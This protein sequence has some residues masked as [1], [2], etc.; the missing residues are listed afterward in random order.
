M[1]QQETKSWN[2]WT[3]SV[4]AVLLA[5]VTITSGCRSNPT[6]PQ[7]LTPVRTAAVQPI[8]AGTSNTY[9]ANIQPYQQV[10]LAFK[11][12]GYLVSIRQVKDAT[13][14][15]RNIDQGDWVAK[16]TV[17]ATVDEGDYKEKLQQAKAQLDRAQANYDRAKLSFDRMSVLYQNG[18]ATKP[19]YDNANAQMLDGLASIQSA[20]ASIAEQ[21]IALGYCEL[22]APFDGWLVKRNVDVGQLVGPATNGFTISD[23]R[24]VK[25]VFGVPDTS[26][27]HIRLGSPETITTD[28]LPG[29]FNG[30]VTSIS[31]SADPKSRVY[32]VEVTIPNGDNR[33]KAGMIASIS[34]GGG[35]ANTRVDVVPLTAVVRSPGNPNG[36]AVFV[37]EGAG[38]TVKVHTQDV[39]LG[40]TYGNNI[41]VLSGLGVKDRVVTS[42]TNMIRNGDQV[43]VIP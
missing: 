7:P 35:K 9:S 25:A 20:K 13:G 17:L 24:S 39:T 23:V 27:E 37:T 14:R 26:M 41:A 33:L 10:D 3:A 4:L 5:G 36:F 34:I 32:S 22:R 42:G 11:S 28:A 1:I 38:D 29:N 2:S 40:D 30:H 18:A 12:N 43:R 15:M 21:Q 16:G 31:P 8:D 19:D 6:A